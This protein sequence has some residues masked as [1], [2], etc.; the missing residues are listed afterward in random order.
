VSQFEY[1]NS[2]S[3]PEMSEFFPSKMSLLLG[4][5][6]PHLEHGSPGPHESVC[7]DGISIGSSVFAGHAVVANRQTNTQTTLLRLRSWLVGVEFNA[8]LDTI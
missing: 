2:R 8:P 1:I 3:C 6:G 7:P 4:D 5:P